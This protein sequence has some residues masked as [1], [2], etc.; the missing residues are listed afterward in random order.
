MGKKVIM[1][2]LDQFADWEGAFISNALMSGEISQDNQVLWASTDKDPKRSMGQM[3][4][5]PDITLEE[6]PD[7]ADALLLIGGRSWRGDEAKKVVAVV[8]H[9]LESQKL[10]GFIC[11]ATYFAADNGFLNNVKH[12][13]NDPT[14]MAAAPGYTGGEHYL[15]ENAVADQKIVTA[16]GNSPVE[17]ATLILEELEAA[18][19]TDIK[20]WSDFYTIGYLNALR[21]YGY[22]E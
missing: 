15:M 9:F 13:G 2:V 4:V 1:I 17:F 6:I 18:D 21:K 11:D 12:T 10:V 3:T 19:P 8:E 20:M 22:L 5:L 14:D 16:N 7:D